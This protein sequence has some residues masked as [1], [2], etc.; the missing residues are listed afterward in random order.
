VAASATTARSLLF[1]DLLKG[2]VLYSIALF[3]S[4]IGGTVLLPINTRFLNPA[5]YGVLEL[6]EQSTMVLSILLGI[7]F[8]A[9]LGFFYFEKDSEDTRQRAASTAVIGAV[10]AGI[11]AALIGLPLVRPMS[12]LIFGNADSYILLQ[13]SFTFLPLAFALESLF[14]W[15]RI[16]NRP[17]LFTFAS[18]L[19]LG[20]TIVSTIILVAVFRLGVLGV[21]VSSNLAITGVACLLIFYF[22]R[23]VPVIFD[24]RLLVR[25]VR[26]SLPLTAGSVAMFIIHFGDRFILPHYRPL[27][28][29]G[30]YGIAYKIGML[31][32][33][34]YGAFQTYWSAQVFA[35]AKR[36]DADDVIPGIFTY[37]LLMLSICAL[38]LTVF[39]RPAI[40]YLTRPQFEGAAMIAPLIIAAY[41]IRSIAEF[42]RCF[43]VVHA[44]PEYEAICN[45]ISAGVCLASYFIL[46][47]RFGMWGA[48]I[49]TAITF[50]IMAVIAIG[51]SYRLRHYHFEIAR[52]SKIVAVTAGLAAFD[53][54]FPITSPV[55]QILRGTAL[56][57]TLPLMLSL[58]RFYRPSEL[59][60]ARSLLA[61]VLRRAGLGPREPVFTAE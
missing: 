44:H 15:V 49:A 18:F 10:L 34:I 3:G 50:V 51:W 30:I 39:C 1:R 60:H 6:V 4:R 14:S 40:H 33:L 31:I 24:W 7:Q 53:L 36:D 57:L 11:V 12:R 42:F 32:S 27:A 17:G 56:V 43:F 8:S 25:M 35:V 28:E 37:V 58:L 47:P 29:L 38:G 19:R 20:I 54:A 23:R 22:I 52:I 59:A 45:W 55:L 13:L 9:A 2:T 61:G 21:V 26:F 48:A 5:D 41:Y 16:A 46:I